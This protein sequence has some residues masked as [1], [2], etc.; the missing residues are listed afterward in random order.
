MNFKFHHQEVNALG[1]IARNH[2]YPE[3]LTVMKSLTGNALLVAKELIGIEDSKRPDINEVTR[4]LQEWAERRK[5]DEF[6]KY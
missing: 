6:Q 5:K 2:N 3:A 1:F 4:N